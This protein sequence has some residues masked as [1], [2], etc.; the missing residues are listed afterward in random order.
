MSNPVRLNPT[1]ER[2]RV[3]Q[4]VLTDFDPRSPSVVYTIAQIDEQA[5]GCQSGCIVRAVDAQGRPPRNGEWL[6]AAWYRP[7][8]EE[9]TLA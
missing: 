9:V 3:G 1:S 8:K 7:V 5:R 6:D 2:L 4:R